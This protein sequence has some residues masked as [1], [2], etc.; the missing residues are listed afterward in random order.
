M[1]HR[2]FNSCPPQEKKIGECLCFPVD[3]C[4]LITEALD[5]QLSRIKISDNREI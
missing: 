3:D 4:V 1:S 5:E 2:L